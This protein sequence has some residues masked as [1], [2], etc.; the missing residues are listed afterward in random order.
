MER[1]CIYLGFA[2]V[3]SSVSIPFVV[4]NYDENARICRALDDSVHSIDEPDV[5][6]FQLGISRWLHYFAELHLLESN[7]RSVRD[8][9]LRIQ[10][11]VSK[12]DRNRASMS[13]LESET[14][15]RRLEDELRSIPCIGEEIASTTYA[16][17]PY[18]L[19]RYLVVLF[20]VLVISA[21][22]MVIDTLIMSSERE[23]RYRV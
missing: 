20:F 7:Y 21:P 5:S 19:K 11:E 6:V 22:T 2:L 23:M 8:T 12:F 14:E 13:P 10:R 18:V 9:V 4:Q 15:V 1:W 17:F 3:L 16:F